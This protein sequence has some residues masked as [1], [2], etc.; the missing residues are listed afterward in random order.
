MARAKAIIIVLVQVINL[1]EKL[2]KAIV[3]K[4]KEKL[5]ANE[6]VERDPIFDSDAL[7]SYLCDIISMWKITIVIMLLTLI[8]QA[9]KMC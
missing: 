4:G 5:P 7:R 6:I 9:V 1:I 3:G 8:L 2:V